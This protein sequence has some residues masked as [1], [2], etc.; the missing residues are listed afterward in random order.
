MLPT[1]KELSIAGKHDLLNHIATCALGIRS[2]NVDTSLKDTNDDLANYLC[3]LEINFSTKRIDVV[4]SD[5]PYVAT[6][7]LNLTRSHNHSD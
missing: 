5:H 7:Q 2:K 4:I 6:S 1:T 3:S